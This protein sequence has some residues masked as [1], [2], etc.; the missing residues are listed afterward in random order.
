MR[1]ERALDLGN[2]SFAAD[3]RR[4]IGRQVVPSDDPQTGFAPLLASSEILVSEPKEH[5]PIAVAGGN[6]RRR[7]GARRNASER[8][9]LM[10][11]LQRPNRRGSGLRVTLHRGLVRAVHDRGELVAAVARDQV[12]GLS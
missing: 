2:L 3:E 11:N 10:R 6:A 1:F 4:A 8:R 5:V 7:A 12:L 9:T